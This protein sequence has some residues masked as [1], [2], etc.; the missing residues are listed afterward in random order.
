MAIVFEDFLMTTPLPH[1]AFVSELHKKLTENGCKFEIKS[2]KNGYVVSYRW[3]NKTIMN[4]VFR[5]SGILARIYGDN[6]N[7][8][9]AVIEEL[10]ESMHK[11]MTGASDCKQLQNPPQCNSTCVKGMIFH[12]DGDIHKKC[13][14]NGMFFPLSKETERYIEKLIFSELSVRQA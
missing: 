3:D 5:K 6:V 10:P 13:R 2:A 11:I 1:Q 9:E 7:R 14:Y 8:Y 4:W 12:I